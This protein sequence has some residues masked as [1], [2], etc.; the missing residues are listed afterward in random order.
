MASRSVDAPD[1]FAGIVYSEIESLLADH[2][3]RLPD[4]DIWAPASGPGSFTGVRIG[5]TAAKALAEVT[6]RPAV[7]ISNLEA[8]AFAG[9]GDLRAAVMDARRGQVF[10]ALYDAAVSPI[11]E[12][13]VETWPEFLIRLEDRQPQLIAPEESVF[14][15]DGPAS[16][17]NVESALIVGTLAD[18]IA[19]TQ[20]TN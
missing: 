17:I 11:L 15:H 13:S 4:V 1:G 20:A 5:L 8:L 9:S 2:G 19:V 14:G 7:P 16:L 10:T 6:G 18:S 12:P 3:Y